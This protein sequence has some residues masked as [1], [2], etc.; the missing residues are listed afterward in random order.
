MY[1]YIYIY[2]CII[3]IYIYTSIYV[4]VC[5]CPMCLGVYAYSHAGLNR[6]GHHKPHAQEAAINFWSYPHYIPMKIAHDSSQ[7][8]KSPHPGWASSGCPALSWCIS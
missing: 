2:A 1:I 8:G 7:N 5:A 6:P 3:Y 4:C